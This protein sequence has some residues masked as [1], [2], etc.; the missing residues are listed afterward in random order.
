MSVKPW[1]VEEVAN[2]LIRAIEEH[3]EKKAARSVA[4]LFGH[5][6][7]TQERIAVAT[8][9]LAASLEKIEE[10]ELMRFHGS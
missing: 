10:I 6:I 8:E 3:D 1:T 2:T 5:V 9:R 4:M 7:E